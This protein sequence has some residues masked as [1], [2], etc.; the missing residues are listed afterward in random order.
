[1]MFIEIISA[2]VLAMLVADYVCRWLVE[3][4]ARRARPLNGPALHADA[5]RSRI[6]A[7]R[8][9]YLAE[10]HGREVLGEYHYGLLATA[11]QTVRR[12][13]FFARR[14]G[15]EDQPRPEMNDA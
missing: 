4:L 8:H 14:K 9:D 10:I 15:N 13:S 3:W 2:V 12:F 7:V 5:L 6:S 1:M 11:R